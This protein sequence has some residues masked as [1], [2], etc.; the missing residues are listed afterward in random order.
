MSLD[1]IKRAVQAKLGLTVDGIDGHETWTAIYKQICG[2]VLPASA[3]TPQVDTVIPAGPLTITQSAARLILDAEG[4]DQPWR[5]P[6]Y[7]SGISLGP[8]CRSF[9]QNPQRRAPNG[10]AP[11]C[12]RLRRS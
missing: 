7:D 4:V 11:C 9:M 3:A 2:D 1:Q 8:N 5:W 6:G 12:R 10:Q